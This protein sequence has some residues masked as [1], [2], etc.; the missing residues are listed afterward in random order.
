MAPKY[1]TYAS[2]TDDFLFELACQY[3]ISPTNLSKKDVP[4]YNEIKGRK[5]LRARMSA[6]FGWRRGVEKWGLYKMSDWLALCEQFSSASE[7]R[8]NYVAGQNA[9]YRSNLWPQ[10]KKL[11][12]DSGKWVDNLYGM[13]GRRYD[14]KSEMVV[15]NWLHYSGVSYLSHP[16]LALQET[17]QPFKGDFKLPGVANVEVFMCSD[18]NK[19]S[20][21]DLP[22]WAETYLIRRQK[23]GAYYANSELPLISIEA[24]IFR[25]WGLRKYLSHI[26]QQFKNF[27]ILLCAPAGLP[28]AY[29]QHDLGIKWGLEDFVNYA[30]TNHIGSF[31]QFQRGAPDLYALTRIKGLAKEV[32]L[33]L[34]ALHNR[35]SITYKEDLRPIADVRADCRRLGIV[36]R[37]Q[38]NEAYKKGLFPVG[39]PNSIRQSYGMD[40]Y[41]FINGRKID[42]FWHWKD[43]KKFVRAFNFQSKTEFE[44]YPR[45]GGEWD[46]I[47]KSPAAPNGGYPEWTN[48]GDFLGNVS[49]KEQ[50]RRKA[51]IQIT[52]ELIKEFKTLDALA[53]VNHLKKLGLNNANQ[54]SARNR[55]YT[56]LRRRPDWIELRDKLASRIPKVKTAPEAIEILLDEKCFYWSDFLAMRNSNSRLQS[57]PIHLDRLGLGI[58]ERVR[59]LVG[60]PLVDAK[61][62]SVRRLTHQR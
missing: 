16:K 56:N 39:T 5:N 57:I 22:T 60:L 46:F 15:A 21:S 24:E 52:S 13:D 37:A 11:M 3:A 9:A 2:A 55:L 51:D 31:S 1:K 29:S 33:A 35:R 58:F 17:R 61:V 23:K 27:G 62:R 7:F 50:E 44:K 53:V 34:D 32:R 38:Y 30:K 12:V 43:A 19:N 25:Q 48:W 40:W 36:E 54:L 10:I 59:E 18:I 49:A 8:S 45:K 41:E 42:G 20:R 28:I 6:T 4:L 14:S 26:K 47:R